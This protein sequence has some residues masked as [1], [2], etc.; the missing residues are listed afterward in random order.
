MWFYNNKQ[1]SGQRPPQNRNNFE[2]KYRKSELTIP[3]SSLSPPLPPSSYIYIF[4]IIS[5]L[6]HSIDA[7]ATNQSLLIAKPSQNYKGSKYT[8]GEL[9]NG[10]FTFKVSDDIDMDPCKSSMYTERFF[11]VHDQL[12]LR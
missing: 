11:I 8:I 6:S 2:K 3:Q 5:I 12:F 9:L 7:F 4:L 10:R 1:S